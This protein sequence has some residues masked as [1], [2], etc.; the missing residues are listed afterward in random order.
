MNFAQLSLIC[1]VA[2]IGPALWLSKT[3]RVPVVIGEL[4]VGLAL[5]ATGF[6]VLQAG[7]P[8]FSFLADIG[9]ALVMFIAGSHVPVRNPALKKGA[10]KGA[11]RALGIAVLSIVL[12]IVVARAFHNSHAAMYAVL[13]A[14]SSASLIMPSLEGV[15]L[16]GRSMVEMLPQLALADA[17]CIVALPFAIDPAHVTRAMTGALLVL[18]AAGAVF[19]LLRLV[20]SRGYRRRVHR[21]SEERGLAL[22]LRVSLALLFGLAALAQLTHV[23]VM[24]AGFAF[25]LAVAGVGEPRRLA[26]QVFALTEGFFGPIFFVWLGASLNLRD[27]A[28]HPMAIALGI[29]L[30]V[31]ALL[32]HGAL[33]A[34]KQPWPLA[35]TTAAQLGVPVAAATTGTKLHLLAP[36]EATAILL[37]AII[38]IAVT[39]ALSGR[40]S[41]LA[42]AE[43]AAA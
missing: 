10:V 33:V 20:E 35:L 28:S 25:G 32:A 24:L 22:E 27:L 9:F 26:K 3:A 14:S 38:T 6:R 5:G 8:T 21:V 36:G 1:L 17:L 2:I 19:A 29:A 11:A 34:T 4:A 23:S 7:D 39:T 30:G 37:G 15:P 31:G 16:T 41:S 13:M 42:Q 40:V 12:G 18:A 43:A